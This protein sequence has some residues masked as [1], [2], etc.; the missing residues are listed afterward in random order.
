MQTQNRRSKLDFSI[1]Y[2]EVCWY[3]KNLDSLLL[4]LA[5]SRFFCVW[6]AR[7]CEMKLFK[8]L[9]PHILQ[10]PKERLVGFT[11]MP[12]GIQFMEINSKRHVMRRGRLKL[13]LLNMYIIFNQ[14]RCSPMHCSRSWIVQHKSRVVVMRVWREYCL[15]SRNFN[16]TIWWMSWY[17]DLAWLG[18]FRRLMPTRI[19]RCRIRKPVENTRRSKACWFRPPKWEKT[20]RINVVARSLIF[21]IVKNSTTRFDNF[22]FGYFTCCCLF[23][24][25]FYF[26]L[27]FMLSFANN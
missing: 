16:S 5:R 20:T 12:F 1:F 6:L 10:I 4:L 19:C 14:S 2:H 9:Q 26:N 17:S 3:L 7:V 25:F 24:V 21:S 13:T 11:S 22:S 23:L 15:S 8:R 18:T 27:S